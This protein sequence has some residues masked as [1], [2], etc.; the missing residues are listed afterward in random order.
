MLVLRLCSNM[1]TGQEL[2]LAV[3][4]LR[5]GFGIVVQAFRPE[6]VASEK[7]LELSLHLARKAEKE[8]KMMAKSL[9]NEFLLFA[10][11]GTKMNDAIAKSGVKDPADFILA[12]D[13][14]AE[15]KKEILSALSASEKKIAF[16]DAKTLAK[17]FVLS[18]A[19]LTNFSAEELVLEKVA[20]ARLS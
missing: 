16:A 9:D 14:K 12:T 4:K 8:N 7:H 17:E 5:A 20:L 2:F 13:C 6:C 10:S 11:A 3:A 19:A 1:K 18:E 15:K